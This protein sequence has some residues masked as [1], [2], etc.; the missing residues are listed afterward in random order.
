MAVRNP[1]ALGH[2]NRPLNTWLEKSS[3]TE[4]STSSVPITIVLLFVYYFFCCL[5]GNDQLYSTDWN[6][7]VDFGQG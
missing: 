7:A 1:L 2:L 6:A 5:S 3:K 4:I